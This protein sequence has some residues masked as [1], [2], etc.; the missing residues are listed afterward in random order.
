MKAEEAFNVINNLHVREALRRFQPQWSI[1]SI[2]SAGEIM[3]VATYKNCPQT[4]EQL[5]VFNEF[6]GSIQITAWPDRFSSV[7]ALEKVV[8]ESVDLARKY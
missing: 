3:G 7:E 8:R 2:S 1:V 5:D 4:K 6:P